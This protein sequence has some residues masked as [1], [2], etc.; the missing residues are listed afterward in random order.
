MVGQGSDIIEF[1]KTHLKQLMNIKCAYCLMNM[2]R[3]ER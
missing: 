3:T 1:K 2:H